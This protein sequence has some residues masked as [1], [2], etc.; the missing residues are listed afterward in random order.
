M[1]RA[2]ALSCVL[3]SSAFAV[4][5]TPSVRVEA[6]Q[7]Q[8]SRPLESQTASAVVKDYIESWKALHD[9]LQQNDAARLD[10]SFVGIAHDTLSATIDSQRRS[11]LQTDYQDRSHDIRIVFYSPEGL[12][13]QLLDD[14]EYEQKVVHKDKTLTTRIVHEHYVV[15]MTPSEARWQVRIFQTDHS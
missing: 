7:L 1:V 2:L 13:I 8:G 15:V 3:L 4:A 12:S 10:P 14:V 6:P 9:A 5:A 11:E